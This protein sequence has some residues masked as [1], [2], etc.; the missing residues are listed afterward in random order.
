MQRL[1]TEARADLAWFGAFLQAFNGVTL[2]K[3]GIANVVVHVDSCLQGGGRICDG[4]GYYKQVYPEAIRKCEF[5]INALECLNTLIAIRLLV[6]RMVGV[7]C[8]DFRGQLGDCLCFKFRESTRSANER[9][10][11]GGMV[12]SCPAGHQHRGEA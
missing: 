11:K 4:L 6:Q 12:D 1:T 7:N 2:I 8:V 5:S 10:I 3:S 9:S